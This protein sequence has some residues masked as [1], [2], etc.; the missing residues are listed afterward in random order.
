MRMRNIALK[1]Q[2]SA[3][4]HLQLRLRI[5]RTSLKTAVEPLPVLH[6]LESTRTCSCLGFHQFGALRS[7]CSS[8]H[9]NALDGPKMASTAVFKISEAPFRSRFPTPSCHPAKG[10]KVY[11]HRPREI[12]WS[13]ETGACV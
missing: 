13:S 6:L 3:F 8:T 7:S 12:Q 9:N 1:L 11:D 5:F 4:P 2:K 10:F